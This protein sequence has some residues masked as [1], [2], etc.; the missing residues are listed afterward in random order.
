MN[1][2]GPLVTRP[3]RVLRV[4][5]P[6]RELMG[7]LQARTPKVPSLASRAEVHRGKPGPQDQ[8]RALSQR[9]KRE[10][11][12]PWS[13]ATGPHLEEGRGAATAPS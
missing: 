3:A 7:R 9:S 8:A 6:P 5:L 12:S 1:A 11:R 10:E 13:A 4:G 2:C